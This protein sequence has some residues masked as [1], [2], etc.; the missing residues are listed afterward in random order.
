MAM[1]SR[2][3]EHQSLTLVKGYAA[4]LVEDNFGFDYIESIEDQL[5]QFMSQNR[6]VKGVI[7]DFSSVKSSD[8]M[9]LLRLEGML[10]SIQLIGGRI[11][12]CGIHA[13]LA[14][15]IIQSA[16]HLTHHAT[17]HDLDDVLKIL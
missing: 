8:P 2:N 7:L 1:V 9:D 11:G 10:K 14:A 6:A 12:F 15:L 16:I 13:G 4:L 5:L 3:D 17:G